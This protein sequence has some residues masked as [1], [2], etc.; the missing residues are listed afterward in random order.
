MKQCKICNKDKE[1]TDFH[2]NKQSSD[3]YERRCKVCRKQEAHVKYREYP[4]TT[5]CRCKKAEAKKKGIPFDLT[6]SYLESIYTGNCVIFNK[7]LVFGVDGG[8]HTN[9]AHLDRLVPELG[10]V[11]GN[12]NFISGR[13]NRI[14]YDATISELRVIAD[15]IEG[16]TTNCTLK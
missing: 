7:P 2:K 13:A 9:S 15:W 5:L 14:K 10:Y 1:L 16:A 11:K 3:G 6:P 8:K 12:V 4:F